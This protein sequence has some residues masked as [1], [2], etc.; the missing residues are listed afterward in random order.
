M[1]FYSGTLDDRVI[2]QAANREFKIAGGMVGRGLTDDI[3]SSYFLRKPAMSLI[4][5]AIVGFSGVALCTFDQHVGARESRIKRD[6][7]DV[8]ILQEILQI[9]NSF[10][11]ASSF[12]VS[13][14]TG[15]TSDEM[16]NCH[17]AK[18]VGEK[19]IAQLIGKQFINI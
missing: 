2:E 3:L 19:I 17:M 11:N 9:K 7:K 8:K 5:E 4:S 12:V 13:L 16:M 10:K 18:E 6:Y 15:I 1:K 14:G